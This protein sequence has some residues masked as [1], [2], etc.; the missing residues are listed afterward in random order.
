MKHDPYT[1]LNQETV[2]QNRWL[3]VEVHGITHPN[4]AAGEHVVIVTPQSCGVL[5]ED[6]GYLLFARQPRFAARQYVTEIVKG[7][8]CAGES[9]LE[10]AKRELHE[11]LGVTAQSWSALGTLREIPSIVDP[12][13]VLFL[14]RELKHGSPEPSDEES[15]TTVRLTTAA[16]LDAAIRGEIDDAVTVA[17]LFRFAAAAGYLLPPH[18]PDQHQNRERG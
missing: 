15:I 4:G 8:S 14:A 18:D 3:S 6:N 11:E 7:G 5:A 2:Y 17:A 9:L 1:R 13:V 16:A 10:S 12:P